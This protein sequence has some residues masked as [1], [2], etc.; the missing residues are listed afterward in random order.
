MQNFPVLPFVA[1]V[2][3]SLGVIYVLVYMRKKTP[4]PKSPTPEETPNRESFEAP[5]RTPVFGIYNYLNR[6]IRLKGVYGNSKPEDIGFVRPH[7]LKTFR[8]AVIERYLIAGSRIEVYTFDEDR[9]G[10]KER[11]FGSYEMKVPE[12]TTIRMLH[13]GMITGRW[14]GSNAIDT[15]YNP[16]YHAVQ[17]QAWIKIHNL[18]D[19]PLALNENINISPGG[20]LRYSGRDHFGVRLGTVF[21]DQDG[22]F[23]DY[24][25]TIPATDIYY[26]VVSDIQQPLFGGFQLTPEF[27]DDPN[28]PQF[29]LEEG[30]YYSDAKGKIP[31][32]Y[33]PIEGPEVSPQNRWGEEILDQSYL[34]TPVGSPPEVW[35]IGET[36]QTLT[37]LP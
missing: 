33:L 31:Y 35:T 10:L 23:P 5:S 21:R 36:E 26:G 14:V 25:Y 6:S 37:P 22:I 18:T 30:W 29:L 19:F 7:S 11:Y 4:K 34:N 16:G 27:D 2:I 32:G 12:G 3:I 1:V 17:G 8:R 9:S 28:E 24:I 15:A 13:V 20:V